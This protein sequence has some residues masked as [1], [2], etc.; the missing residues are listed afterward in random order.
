[1]SASIVVLVLTTTVRAEIASSAGSPTSVLAGGNLSV[2]ASDT[3]LD[4]GLFAGWNDPAKFG[5]ME[6]SIFK[7]MKAPQGDFRDF[8]AVDGW[9]EQ[10]TPQRGVRRC[11]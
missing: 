1:M 7:L 5:F 10:I 6:R 2:T 11:V 4:I 8:A 9:T 3:A